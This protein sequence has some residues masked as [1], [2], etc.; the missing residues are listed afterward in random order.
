M[1][2][3]STT[4]QTPILTKRDALADRLS[5]HFG[6]KIAELGLELVQ[7]RL[8][9]SNRA[10]LRVD[11]RIDRPVG[12]GGVTL[13]DCTRVSRLIGNALDL[14]E[15]EGPKDLVIDVPYELEVSS[16]GMDRVLRH[17][18]DFVRFIGLTAKVVVRKDGAQESFLGQIEAAGDGSVTLA[19]GKKKPSKVIA[20][21]DVVLANLAPTFA[22]WL[23]LGERLK[24]ESPGGDEVVELDEEAEDPD[25]E[26]DGTDADD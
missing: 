25:A 20:L 6:E 4:L 23:A 26:E 9:G 24:A 5:A 11:V 19:Q 21:A 2:P 12:Q 3:A 16:P 15:V 10:G 14:Y 18:A 7:F 17:E 13:R 1:T 8:L 22:E